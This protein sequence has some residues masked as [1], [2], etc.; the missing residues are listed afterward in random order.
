[1]ASVRD[2]GS[3]VVPPDVVV[4]KSTRTTPNDIVLLHDDLVRITLEPA[5]T[6]DIPLNVSELDWN[7]QLHLGDFN[8]YVLDAGPAWLDPGSGRPD[9]SG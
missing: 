3:S 2:D 1:M 7:L 8:V 6:A 5:D 9:A 4:P